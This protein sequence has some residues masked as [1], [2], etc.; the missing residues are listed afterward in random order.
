[1]GKNYRKEL[2]NLNCIYESAMRA[3]VDVLTNFLS[4]YQGC[5][6]FAIGSGDLILWRR[7]SSI[8]V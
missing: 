3:D 5:H 7:H 8:Y 1:M 2:D 4:K 6:L